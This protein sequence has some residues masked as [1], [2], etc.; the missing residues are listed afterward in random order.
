M[1]VH[2]LII[3]DSLTIVLLINFLEMC[4]HGNMAMFIIC[5]LIMIV[6]ENM[7]EYV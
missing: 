3:I 6:F 1:P 4:F 7:I 2:K 5:L